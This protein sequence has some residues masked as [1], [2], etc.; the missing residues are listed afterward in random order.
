MSTFTETKTV[1]QITVTENGIVLY[2][3]ATR[4]LKDG[5]QIAQTYHRTSLI[6]AQDLTGV[7]SNV[8]AICNT[9]WTDAVISAYQAQ[10][11]EQNA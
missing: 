11:A 2:R 7:P 1:D 4:I 9:A 5:E 8:V 10:V 3:E 6:P